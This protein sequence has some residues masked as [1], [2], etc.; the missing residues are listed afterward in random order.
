MSKKTTTNNILEVLYLITLGASIGNIKHKESADKTTYEIEVANNEIKKMHDFY[1]KH[2][3]KIDVF[4]VK[5]VLKTLDSLLNFQA[6]LIKEQG[7]NS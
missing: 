2:N 5:E 1:Q 4:L 6:D 7:G 3:T